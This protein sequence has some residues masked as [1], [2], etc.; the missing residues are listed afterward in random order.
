MPVDSHVIPILILTVVFTLPLLIYQ[1]RR[2]WKANKLLEKYSP[3]IELE[4]EIDKATTRAK[5]L[6]HQLSGLSQDRDVLVKEIALLN[7]DNDLLS[8]G[9]YKSKYDFGDSQKY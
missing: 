3:I 7:D 4:K 1:T 9:F 8:A 6:S 2:V 5:E